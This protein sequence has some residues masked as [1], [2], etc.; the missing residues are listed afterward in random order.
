L[1]GENEEPV[2]EDEEYYDEYDEN[3]G[4]RFKSTN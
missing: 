4:K 3:E 1:L 2:N